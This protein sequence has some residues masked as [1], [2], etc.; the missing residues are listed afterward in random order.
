MQTIKLTQRT[1]MNYIR[2]MMRFGHSQIFLTSKDGVLQFS[3]ISGDLRIEGEH[4]VDMLRM[5]CERHGVDDNA[6]IFIHSNGK[7]DYFPASVPQVV[8]M[9]K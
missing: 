6:Q 4:L 1:I 7:Q 5:S 8:A 3:S 2:S 9:G